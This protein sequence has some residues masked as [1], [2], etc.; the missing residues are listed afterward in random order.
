ML[1]ELIFNESLPDVRESPTHVI[2]IDEEWKAV[3]S[4]AGHDGRDWRR[5]M[6]R[7]TMS[8]LVTLHAELRQQPSGRPAVGSIGSCAVTD[9]LIATMPDR[10]IMIDERVVDAFFQMISARP[11]FFRHSRNVAVVAASSL[12]SGIRKYSRVVGRSFLSLCQMPS[13][14]IMPHGC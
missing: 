10:Q 13:L 1:V 2:D 6:Q 14:L 5:W 11:G 12:S 7:E 4:L 8:K 9:Q 3:A